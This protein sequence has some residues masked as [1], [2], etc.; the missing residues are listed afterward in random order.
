MSIESLAI[1]MHHSRAEGTARMILFGIANHDG[2]G[3]AWPAIATLAK[4]ARCDRR[5]AQRAIP[6]L[7]ALGEI[8]CVQNG[9]GN[10]PEKTVYERPN[11]Y[12]FLLECPPDCDRS[13]NHRT[14]RERS[15]V[16]LDP[17]VDQMPPPYAALDQMPPGEAD[18]MPPKP[19]SNPSKTQS[20]LSGSERARATGC[21]E[22]ARGWHRYGPGGFCTNGCGIELGARA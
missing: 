18:E 14:K 11:R 10:D 5:T 22:D 1:A 8:R 19:S 12:H 15:Q 21:T 2:D 17:M 7:V 4:Y 13:K 20:A 9:G 3:G 16:S 6:K